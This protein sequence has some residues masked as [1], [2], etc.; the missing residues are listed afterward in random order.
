MIDILH[1]MSKSKSCKSNI[2]NIILA[3]SHMR[4]EDEVWKLH[5]HHLLPLDLLKTYSPH[6]K[7]PKE[8]TT[9]GLSTGIQ[10]NDWAPSQRGNASFGGFF[11]RPLAM[12]KWWKDVFFFTNMIRYTSKMKFSSE[13]SCGVFFWHYGIWWKRC[14]SVANFLEFCWVKNKNIANRHL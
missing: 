5:H 11:E 1:I 10:S 14:C 13:T 8:Q 12:E 6:Q 9:S 7:N 4:I 3:S 2:T